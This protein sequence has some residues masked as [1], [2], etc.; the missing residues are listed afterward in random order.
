MRKHE[1]KN[2]PK[3]QRRLRLRKTRRN[4]KIS[5]RIVSRKEG[6]IVAHIHGDPRERGF[7][8]GYLLHAELATIERRM[9]FI[10]HNFYG[11]HMTYSKYS[12]ECSRHIV[13][14]VERDFPEYYAEI[15]GISTGAKS[16]GVAISTKVL[17]EWNAMSSM[18]SYFKD[19]AKR[20]KNQAQRCSAFIATG[21]TTKH[22]DI[23]MAHNTHCDF[24]MAA[25]F[26]I[27][28][29]ITP[30]TG[31]PFVIQTAPGLIQSMTDWFISASGIIGCETTISNI[32]YR[33][34]FGAPHFCRIRKAIQYGKSL[35][36][37]IAIM[38]DHNAGDYACSWLL[39]D[40]NTNEIMLF[41]LGLKESNVERTKNGVFYGANSAMG[42]ALREKETTDKSHD[43]TQTS[44][45][46]RNARFNALFA[47]HPKI[48]D[49]LAQKIIADHH[50]SYLKIDSMNN[51]SI[52]R[53]SE[54]DA[55]PPHKGQ[56]SY[57]PWGAT[58]GK[59]VNSRQAKRLEFT[60]RFGSSCGREFVAEDFLEKHAEYKGWAEFMP[61]F[62]R[63]EWVNITIN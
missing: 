50:D 3:S 62:P 49:T 18:H 4:S 13:P 27:I 15:E 2:R 16:A 12:K 57:Y 37:Y 6:W 60:G 7:A 45:G 22:G 34:K 59:T 11:K 10:I 19:G 28:L 8:H 33:P 44:S 61:D 54:L 39:G 63:T 24:P 42:K 5:G 26:N 32:N 9:K 43:D 51:R 29:Y 48:D 40:I 56:H 47:E 35:D 58:D 41:E 21:S 46:S 23:I 17:I 36:D 14:V 53:H 30:D 38:K 31:M 52:C 1:T 25:T 20:T 55:S